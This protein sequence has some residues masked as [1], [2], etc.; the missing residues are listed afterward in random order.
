V[1]LAG[2][3][4]MAGGELGDST[5][6]VPLSRRNGLP[7]LPEGRAQDLQPDR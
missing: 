3:S 6:S 2:A 4:G 1:A 5:I 7:V